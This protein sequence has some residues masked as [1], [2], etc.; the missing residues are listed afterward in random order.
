MQVTETITKV[1]TVIDVDG[2]GH[3]L[4]SVSPIEGMNG[5]ELVVGAQFKNRA[6]SRFSKPALAELIAT[7]QEI[8]AAM[9]D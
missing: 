1:A 7:L 3:S 6:A 2:P 4:F 9:K 8:H 5:I